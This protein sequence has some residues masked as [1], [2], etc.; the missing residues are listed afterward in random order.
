MY[1]KLF[2]I[3]DFAQHTYGLLVALGFVVALWLVTRLARQDGL[4][5]DRVFNLA[6]YS[7]LAGFLGAK[8][9]FLVTDWEYYM[10]NPRQALSLQ[11]L[12]AGGVFYGGFL[13]AVI[14]A[15]WYTRR[16]RLPFLKT[17]DAV[18]PAVALGHA[19]GRL[20]CF[21]AGCCWGEP[22]TLPWAVTFTDPYA[23]QTFGVPLGIPL[24]PTQLYEAAAEALIFLF[25][26]WQRTRKRFDGQIFA[27]YLALY[28]AVRF[29]LEFLRDDPERGFLFDGRLS[30]SQFIAPVLIAVSAALWYWK[31]PVRAAGPA[32]RS[33]KS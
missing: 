10:L 19:V 26:L 4:D 17:G 16:A 28:G 14:F 33:T 29:G 18:V 6:V 22:S 23:H 1:P 5:A 15:A 32:G 27:L 30:T 7:A 11:S 3:G 21:S 8:L 9:L 24:H 20:G 25:L 2:T 12:Q 31:R 13:G